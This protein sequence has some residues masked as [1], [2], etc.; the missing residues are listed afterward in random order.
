VRDL[1]RIFAEIKD[2]LSAGGDLL[3][4]SDY[5][6]TLT[7]IVSDP[8]E[9]WLNPVVRD[10][11]AALAES[12]RVRIGVISGRALH[13]LRARVGVPEIIYASC[14]GLEAQGPGI[15]FTHPEAE[16]QRKAIA[17]LAEGL[18]SLLAAIEGACVEPKGLTVAVHYRDVPRGSA[19]LVRSHLEQVLYEHGG[20]F[21]VLKGKK[22][23]EI[24]PH[25][26][27]NKGECALWI[28]DRVLPELRWPAA[29][30]Y[31]GDDQTDELAFK[32]LA[33]KAVTVRVGP[34]GRRSAAT[35]RLANVTDVHRLLSALAAEVSGK[36]GTAGSRQTTRSLRRGAP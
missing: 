24:L 29:T 19:N 9:A 13:D 21:K 18:T 32:T 35:H 12:P 23:A 4:L 28:R 10:D 36:A 2:V 16:T 30:L 14:H 11:L 5:D 27:W 1:A 15:A 6:G 22:V 17:A 26:H 33:G 7:P 31:M 34:S 20:V 3:L 8:A 25:V